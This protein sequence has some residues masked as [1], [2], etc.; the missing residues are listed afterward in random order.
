MLCGVC[1]RDAADFIFDVGHNHFPLSGTLKSLVA[2][3]VYMPINVTQE[4]LAAERRY[5]E[6]HT[7]EE[8]LAAL[9][10]MIRTIPKHKGTENVRA[11]LVSKLAKMK[12][13]AAAKAKQRGGRKGPGIKKEGEAQICV[14]GKTMTGKSLLLAKLT[15][16]KPE[17]AEHPFTTTKPQVGMMHVR[18]VQVQ[19]V[20]IPATFEPQN[21]SLCKSSDAIALLGGTKDEVEDAREALGRFFVRVPSVEVD[22]F[23]DGV[24]EM[25]E[26]LW[27]AL[28]LIIVFTKNKK[29]LSPMA[30]PKNAAVRDFAAR[31]HKDFLK[32][33]RFAFLWR[34][35]LK[36]QVG[37]DY[38]LEDG[39][40]VEIRLR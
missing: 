24:E 13:D 29:S 5:Q 32:H 8:K 15:D 37:L 3:L 35:D 40:V 27:K 4:Y 22:P 6:A 30:L 12:K 1:E 21:L 19:L 10:E 31:I 2:F 25:R 17:L 23:K 36:K 9:E 33:F 39:D 7:Q 14:V 20:E 38:R 28:G 11:Q 16:A 18:G 26:K 34:G